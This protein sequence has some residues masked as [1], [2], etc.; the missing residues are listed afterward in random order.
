MNDEVYTKKIKEI[1]TQDTV[2]LDSSDAVREALELMGENRVTALPVVDRNKRCVGILSAADL[3]DLSRD[4]D[5][6]LRD[7]D[8]V[9]L[10]TKRFLIDKLAHSFGDEKVQTFMSESPVTVGMETLIVRAA[11]EMLRNRIH[12]LPVVD[13]DQRLIGIVSTMDILGEFVDAAPQ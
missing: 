1:V 6:D 13:H 4:T 11:R 2:S 10:S 8:L 9:D 12:H 7:L 3:V 5:E